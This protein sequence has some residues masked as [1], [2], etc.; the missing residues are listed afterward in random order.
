MKNAI[1]YAQDIMH[2]SCSREI[3]VFDLIN[4]KSDPQGLLY[5]GVLLLWIYLFIVT[6]YV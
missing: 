6:L 1:I 2:S 5:R 4:I 3:S